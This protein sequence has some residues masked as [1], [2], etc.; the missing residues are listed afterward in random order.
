M[1]RAAWPAHLAAWPRSAATH[2]PTLP[3]LPTPP[4]TCSQGRAGAGAPLLGPLLARHRGLAGHQ[5]RAVPGAGGAGGPSVRA[6]AARLPA[7]RARAPGALP[8]VCTA[9]C[10][11]CTLHLGVSPAPP[12]LARPDPSPRSSPASSPPSPPPICRSS[13]GPPPLPPLPPRAAHRLHLR[14]PHLLLRGRGL[15]GAGGHPRRH[16][17]ARRLLRQPV[18][19]AGR[20]PAPLAALAARL[21]RR[22]AVEPRHLGAGALWR[23]QRAPRGPRVPGAL[24]HEGGCRVLGG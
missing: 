24:P 11:V 3:P 17:H 23:Q 19:P 18:Q 15:R 12:I 16:H 13:P 10:S 7:A 8:A 4:S 20:A 6:A 9:A 1:P 5:L 22:R 14:L 21:L 2:P